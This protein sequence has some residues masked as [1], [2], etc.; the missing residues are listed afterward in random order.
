MG[1]HIVDEIETLFPTLLRILKE[2][3]NFKK[4]ISESKKQNEIIVFGILSII[5]EFMIN[6][7][8][9]NSKIEVY[10]NDIISISINILQDN[11]STSSLKEETV[12]YTILSIL[13]H[14]KKE[15]NIYSEYINLLKIIIRILKKSQNKKKLY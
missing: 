14:S 4:D 2:E 13:T 11:L 7:Y 5:S 6:Q 3:T 10:I 1:N 8:D 15:W 12:L 9:D